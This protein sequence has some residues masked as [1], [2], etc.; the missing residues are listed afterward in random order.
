MI[1][2]VR[3]ISA[4]CITR[5][6]VRRPQAVGGKERRNQVSY[7][8]G[9]RVGLTGACT[10]DD[11]KRTRV[12]VSRPAM[13]NGMS[14]L[15]VESRQV[16]R[17]HWAPLPRIT[18]KPECQ[19]SYTGSVPWSGQRVLHATRHPYR[20]G[21][22]GGRC[23]ESQSS[24]G[25]RSTSGRSRGAARTPVGPFGAIDR[26]IR[27]SARVTLASRLAA[28]ASRDGASASR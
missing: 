7:P 20:A 18:I 2:S 27:R 23:Q 14:L 4:W 17:R 24:R 19:P 22:D 11:E 13:F 1:N 8:M 21:L 26:D 16:R 10:G 12:S 6:P 3:L 25:R 15:C 9:Q 28:M 5:E